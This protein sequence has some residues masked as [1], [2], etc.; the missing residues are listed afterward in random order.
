LEHAPFYAVK[1]VPRDLGT[2]AGLKA[3]RHARVLGTDG[4]PIAGLYAV[5]NDMGSVFG[6][7]YLAGGCTLGPA[8]TFGFIAGRHLAAT[9]S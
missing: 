6:G 9:R 2:F 8:M 3:D 7:T 4:Q 1:V 5:G